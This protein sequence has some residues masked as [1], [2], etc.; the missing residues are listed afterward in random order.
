MR[1]I[2]WLLLLA[3]AFTIPWEYSL[4]L[5][6]PLGNVARITGLLLLAAAI[7]SVLQAGRARMPGM[8]LWLVAALYLWICCTCFWSIDRVATL[9]KLRAFFQEMMVVWM[10]WEFAESPRDLRMLF[11]ATV[12][13]CWVL[14]VLTLVEFRSAAML[15][16]GQ[17]RFAAFGQDPNDVARFLDLGFPM[18]ALLGTSERSWLGK[19]VAYGYLP[20]ALLTVMLTASRGGFLAAMVAVVGSLLLLSMGRPRTRWAGLFALPAIVAV[21]WCVVPAETLQRLATIPEQLSGGSLNQRFEIWSL[22]WRAFVK[23]P[24]LGYGMGN[25]SLAAGLSPEDTA[26]N[27]VLAIL[28][29]GGLCALT[30]CVAIVWV[31]IRTIMRLRARVRIALAT[32]MAVWIVT[33]TVAT[34]EESRFTWLLFGVIAVTG[35]LAQES[36]RAMA[37]CFPEPGANHVSADS[38]QAVPGRL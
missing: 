18:A 12:L 5:G 31:A 4:D 10:V 16:A 11:R 22:G 29:G 32:A 15:V 33:A 23:S 13:G 6:A 37:D 8:M 30:V 1:R 9:D 21:V 3:Y 36:P 7:P 20:M 19:L 24:V 17:A 38:S 25:F 27:T 26:H 14:A 2:A 28:V 35:R 34:V